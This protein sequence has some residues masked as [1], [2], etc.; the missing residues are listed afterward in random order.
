MGS[1]FVHWFVIGFSAGCG[2]GIIMWILSK[3]LK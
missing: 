1:E 2:Y 3:I